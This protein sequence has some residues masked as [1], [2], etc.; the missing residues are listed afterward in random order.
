MQ[1]FTDMP[2]MQ[3]YSGNFLDRERGKAGAVYGKHQGICFETQYFPDAVN[4]D[5]FE[6]PVVRAGGQFESVTSYK[7]EF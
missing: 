1:I 6:S 4:K 7:F 2:G 3:V 5:N